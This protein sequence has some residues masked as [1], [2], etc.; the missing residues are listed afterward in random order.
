MDFRALLEADV[1]VE[2]GALTA[3]DSAQALEDGAGVLDAVGEEDRARIEG[4]VET[5]VE[6]AGGD[7]E[8]ALLRRG[9]GR[10]L[11]G[12][13]SPGTSHAVAESGT[14]V[15]APLRTVERERYAGFLPL[16]E[17]GMGVVY[18]AVDTELN[19]QIAFKMI[20]SN[21]RDPLDASPRSVPEELEARFLQEAW[22]TGGLEHP[23]IVP[24]YELGRTPSGV[25]YYTMR[26]IRGERTL[27]DAIS[28][29]RTVEDRLKLLEPFL[30]VCDAVHYAHS[31]AVVHRD[32]KPANIALGP[33]GEVVVLDWG[34]A[35]MTR[36]PGL[37]DSRW[38]ARLRELRE[39]TDLET[40]T[41]ALGTPGYMAREALLG[42]V[43]KVDTRSDIYSL[44]A[45]LYRILAGRLPFSF[46]SF[47]EYVTQVEG[48]V[49]EVPEAPAGLAEVCVKAMATRRRDRYGDAD[50]LAAAIRAWQAESAVERE[51]RGLVEEAEAALETASS[52]E[53]EA[54][55]R[56]L[57]R[58]V[59]LAA[60]VLD[61][62]PGH[63]G[64]TDLQEQARARR[65]EAIAQR[66]RLARRRLLRRVAVAGLVVATAATVVVALLLDAR[67]RE[68]E[69]ARSQTAAA[70]TREQDARKQ[71]QDALEREKTA[72][73]EAEGERDA[74]ASA[75]AQVL[76]LADAKKVRDLLDGMDNLWPI[77]PD[78]APVMAEW[79]ERAQ[80]VLENRAG[81]EETL[82]QVRERAE[83]YSEEQRKE[84]HAARIERLEALRAALAKKEEPPEDEAKR[85]AWAERRAAADKEAKELEA[86]I[87]KRAS[88]RFQSAED[89]WRHQVL[90]DL[91]AG[92]SRLEAAQ[93][94]IRERHEAARTLNARSIDAH[95]KDWDETIQAIAAS[96][97]Y[98]GLKLNP[99]LGL[100]P[101]GPDPDSKLFEFAQVGT[102]ESPK[103]DP[104]SRRF[105]LT[106][107]FAIVLVLIPGGTFRMGAQKTDAKAP[108]YDPQADSGESPVHEATLSPYFLSK[109][110]CTQAQWEKL[111]AERPSLYGPGHEFGGKKVTLRN[112]VEQVSGEDC[113]RWLSRH[114]LV[115]PTETQWEHACRAGTNTPWFTGR[116]AKALESVANS[117]DAFCK[118]NGGPASWPYTEEVNDGHAV[119]APVG[120]FAPNA[121]G[122]HD[123]HGNVWEWSR[124]TR[125]AYPAEA[126]TDPLVQGAG[127]R[128]HRGG[129]YADVAS[130]AR[131]ATRNTIDPSFRDTSLG[132]RPA[133]SVTS[134]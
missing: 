117:A 101:L 126:V 48:G 58:T 85:T 82:A 72:L 106:D 93:A 111:T 53:G 114:N 29:A 131:S 41:S 67:R 49:R 70:L 3:R 2:L 84:D 83:P 51:V 120:S 9:V 75:L 18:L 54:L 25:P 113:T 73:K 63:G 129:S 23:G 110:E 17:G 94:Q 80:A 68:A 59:S 44:G 91:L 37:A 96:S 107:D 19:R 13:L 125:R 79:L 4:R 1:A 42:Q 95:R 43:S 74:K 133:R 12:S 132:V 27:E 64:A 14:R 86:A 76:R 26:V 45:I 102:G 52:L 77:H 40:L 109:Y 123:V 112:P 8:A 20:R 105:V 55:L 88:W 56:Q 5:L 34:L 118:A 121:L 7:A 99:Q 32:L 39:E 65:E 122:L 31:H 38:Q 89:D 81:H 16:G 15:R 47:A 50:G 119:H 69:R 97:K 103:R 24:V 57:D 22:V 66:E 124:D 87:A 104:K 6:G 60:R 78:R 61:L 36:I 10:E 21:G 30:K 62:R 128:V 33:F 134:K 116:E 100:V 98:N 11:H 90:G 28:K 35:K 115:L 127:A 108:N 130:Y 46:G 71:T 92:L